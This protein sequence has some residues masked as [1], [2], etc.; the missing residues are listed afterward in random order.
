MTSGRLPTN[1]AAAAKSISWSLIG[2]RRPTQPTIGPSC[3]RPSGRGPS[4]RAASA[5]GL[6]VHAHG[7]DVP[8]GRPM[9]RARSSS[10]TCGPPRAGRRSGPARAPRAKAWFVSAAKYSCSTWPWKVCTV[11]G[12]PVA[13]RDPAERA[14]L[15]RVRVHDLRAPAADHA[16]DGREAPAGRAIGSQLAG[17]PW[18]VDIEGQTRSGNGGS[19]L[20]AP[21]KRPRPAAYRTPP[22]QRAHG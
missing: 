16:A 12:T 14:G 15:R 6:E 3:G 5:T 8:L 19:D 13:G 2:T 11:T 18:Q 10:R 4:L 1:R 7:H 9:P 22:S 21:R 17:E 20:L